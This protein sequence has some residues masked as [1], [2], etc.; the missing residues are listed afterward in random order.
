MAQ[1]FE[2]VQILAIMYSMLKRVFLQHTHRH[3]TFVARHVGLGVGIKLDT[4]CLSVNRLCG[5]GFQAVVTG[6]TVSQDSF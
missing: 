4:P 6:A 3:G 5:S 2:S 1:V